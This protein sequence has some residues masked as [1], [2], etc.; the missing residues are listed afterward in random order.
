MIFAVCSDCKGTAETECSR[1]DPLPCQKGDVGSEVLQNCLKEENFVGTNNSVEQGKE[2]ILAIEAQE[3][4]QS[5]N[6]S[7]SNP[8]LKQKKAKIS[9]MKQNKA[10]LRGFTAIS[11]LCTQL[12]LNSQVMEQAQSIF[13]AVEQ[14]KR[15]QCRKPSAVLGAV[16]FIA[17]R[18]RKEPLSLEEIAAVLKCESRAVSKCY[19]L[20]MRVIPQIGDFASPIYYSVRYAEQLAFSLEAQQQVQ[21]VAKRL[22]ERG[23]LAGK[24]PRS[25]AGAVVYYIGLLNVQREVTF[26]EVSKVVGMAELTIKS[27]FREIELH[28]REFRMLLGLG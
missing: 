17:C 12:S 16:L 13:Q 8:D 19:G 3:I 21:A 6:I 2:A 26:E 28:Q 20:I 9:E 4:A 24:N 18:R 25:I 23:I 27:A 15:L 5:C 14:S 10:L 22:V 11:A 7:A 1:K